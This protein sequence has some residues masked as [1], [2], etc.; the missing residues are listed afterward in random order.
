MRIDSSGNVG[1]GTS[2]PGTQLNVYKSTATQVAIRPQ[3]SLAYADF[4]PISDGTVYGPYAAPAASTGLIVGT[5][6]SNPVQLWTNGSERMRIDSS[7][8]VGI[9]T[10]SP[11]ALLHVSNASAVIRIGL[12]ATS[13]YTDIYRDNATG[14]TVYNAAQAANFRGHIWQLGGTE[15]MRI[16]SSGNVNVGSSAPVNPASLSILK[17]TTALS[18]TTNSFGMYLYPTSSGVC[19]IDAITSTS[20]NSSLTLRTY[21]NG[22]YNT[23]AMDNGG[24]VTS[25]GSLSDSIGNVRNVP[26]NA[27]TSA[28]VLVA[29]DNGK[30]IAITTGGVTVNSGI[31]S[32]GQSVT[33]YNNSASSQTITQGTSVTMYQVGTANTGNRTLAQRGLCTIFCVA[34]NTFVITGGG[35]T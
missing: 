22:T 17:Q 25:S 8:N 30:H 35:L 7:G 20:G 33:V 27:Q 24:N 12:T 16:D 11:G 3:N 9:G 18:G 2:S 32:A 21:N 4:G 13:Q 19:Y 15:A 6:N 34:S 10:S 28:Y 23:L 5:S 26:Q 14:Y 31:F 29:T 1:I